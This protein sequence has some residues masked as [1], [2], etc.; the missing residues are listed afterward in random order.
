MKIAAKYYFNKDVSQLD[1]AQCAVLA[2][3][4]QNPSANNPARYPD[5][6]RERMEH[7]LDNM[8]RLGH[9]TKAEYDEW[10]KQHKKT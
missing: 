10:Y 8:L 5:D 6:N 7:C 4:T 2:A 3:I 1:L 9:I